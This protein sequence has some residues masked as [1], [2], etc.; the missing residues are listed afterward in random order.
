MNQSNKHM[1]LFFASRIVISSIVRSHDEEEAAL[2]QTEV[3]G[4]IF[5][6]EGEIAKNMGLYAINRYGKSF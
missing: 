6:Y 3:T 1:I 4:R 5:F 2:L